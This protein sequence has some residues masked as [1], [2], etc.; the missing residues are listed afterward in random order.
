M[1]RGRIK[2]RGDRGVWVN[3]EKCAQIT[4]FSLVI[5]SHYPPIQ[6]KKAYI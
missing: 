3:K 4:T 6:S 2:K 5:G 1:L